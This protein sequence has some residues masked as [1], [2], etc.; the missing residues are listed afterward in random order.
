[1]IHKTKDTPRTNAVWK[2]HG[3]LSPQSAAD[4][5][6]LAQ[7]LEIELRHSREEIRRLKKKFM[8]VR[9]VKRKLAGGRIACY[10][11]N[12]SLYAGS[13]IDELA[14]RAWLEL[15]PNRDSL[16]LVREVQIPIDKEQ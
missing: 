2:K 8:M 7:I 12:G 4:A 16:R 3:S 15:Q 9:S 6:E 1:M 5:Y 14:A 13:F 11:A 10:A